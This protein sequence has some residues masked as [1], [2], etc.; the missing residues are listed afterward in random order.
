M[1]DPPRIL[2]TPPTGDNRIF[3]PAYVYGSIVHCLVDTGAGRSFIS[4]PVAQLCQAGRA[5]KKT[6]RVI[7]QVADGRE[8]ELTTEYCLQMKIRDQLHTIHATEF[9]GLAADIILGLDTMEQLALKISIGP[10]E[11][12]RPGA[13]RPQ[14]GQE[15]LHGISTL[16]PDEDHRLRYFLKQEL[17]I[18]N[19]LQGTSTVGEHHIR[20]KH[21]RPLTAR[22]TPRNPAMQAVINQELDDVLAADQIEPSNSPYSAP[23][24]L[25]QKK[26][27]KWRLCVDF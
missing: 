18:F 21:N 12:L 10:H 27:G 17:K 3:I 5:Q 19:R 11:I 15:T 8:F 23:I 1:A 13:V 20:M 2:S 14:P 26:Q 22:Y 4:T 9:P 6:T 24:V 25:V 16:T 7:T